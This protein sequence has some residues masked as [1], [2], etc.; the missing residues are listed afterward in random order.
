MEGH[1]AR[2]NGLIKWVTG[3]IIPIDE[4]ITRKWLYAI[5]QSNNISN[6]F[7]HWKN[8]GVHLVSIQFLFVPS[9]LE[10]FFNKSKFKRLLETINSYDLCLFKVMLCPFYYDKLINH[11]LGHIF[12]IFS[13]HQIS[14]FEC[15]SGW[16]HSVFLL[17]FLPN[18]SAE[19]QIGGMF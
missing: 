6:W 1:G 16:N 7:H 3:V 12:V 19:R 17:C 15:F 4:I 14:K 9:I 18:A 2:I 11:H 8:K 10:T 5:S 13:N